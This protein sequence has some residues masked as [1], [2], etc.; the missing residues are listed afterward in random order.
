MADFRAGCCHTTVA[1]AS[2][3]GARIFGRGYV[4]AETREGKA[5]N[6]GNT[7]RRKDYFSSKTREASAHA[8]SP[9]PKAERIADL[10][11]GGQQLRATQPLK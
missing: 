8:A 9:V 4:E 7:N 2:R 5:W 6:R 10:R 3:F 11:L 1:A